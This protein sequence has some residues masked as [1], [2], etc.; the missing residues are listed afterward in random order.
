M[1]KRIGLFL[2]LAFCGATMF[3]QN[4]DAK[5]IV[6]PKYYEELIKNGNVIMWRDDG[7]KE[8][9]LLP[10]VSWASEIKGNFIPKKDGD[11]PFTYEALYYLSKQ[12]LLKQSNSAAKEITINDVSK[13]CRSISKMQGMKY[14]SSTRKKEVVLYEKAFTIAN[15]QSSEAIPDKTDG[16]ADGMVLYA[17]QD[18]NSFGVTRYELTYKQSAGELLAT[19]KNQDIMGIGPFKAIYPNDM[20]ISLLVIDCGDNLLLYITTDLDSVK[21]PGIKGQITDSITSR[22]EAIYK[23]FVKQF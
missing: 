20:A 4:A 16:S 10:Q 18:D 9:T 1:S 12:D 23:W 6:N 15:A 14:Y 3:A 7:S 8:L 17:L 5:K 19:F 11:Y 21:F 13:I 22:M 2:A